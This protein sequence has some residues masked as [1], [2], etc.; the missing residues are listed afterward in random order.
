[1]KEKSPLRQKDIRTGIQ[2]E[3]KRILALLPLMPTY[4]GLSGTFILR[5]KLVELIKEENK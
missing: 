2:Q 4:D 1:M 3:R 5:D